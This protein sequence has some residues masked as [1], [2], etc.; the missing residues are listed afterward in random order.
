MG[1]QNS[2]PGQPRILI[3]EDSPTQAEKLRHLLER[4]SYQ[5]RAAANGR[6]A[7]EL[8]ADFQP[9]LVI[10]DIVMPEMN[11]YQL[12]SRIKLDPRTRRIP[13]ILLTSLSSSEDVLEGLDCGADYFI[14]KPYSENYL[15]TS[16]EQILLNR[17]LSQEAGE[18]GEAGIMVNGRSRMVAGDQ[19]QTLSLLISTYEAAVRTNSELMQAQD[20]L[21][22]LNANLE[23]LVA[24]RTTAL[25]EENNV[26]RQSEERVRHLNVILRAIRGVNNLT[27]KERDANHLAQ[28]AC[29]IMMDHR[30]YANAFILLSDEQG[31]AVI[32]TTE[33]PNAE[34]LPRSEGLDRE[35][36]PPC[37]LAALESG[38]IF[39]VLERASFC[40][41]CPLQPDSLRNDT[42]CSVLRH[43]GRVHGYLIVSMNR[44]LAQDPENR[45]LFAEMAA[46]LASALHNIEQA[47][48]V[49]Q[50][51]KDKQR[52]EAELRQ[53]QKMEAIGRLAGGVAH[54]FNN[55]LGVIL[56]YAGIALDKARPGETVHDALQQIVLAAE[57]SADLARQLLAFS[58]RQMVTPKVINL[59]HTIT[60]LKKMLTRLIGED[61]EFRLNLAEDIWN[62]LIDP[63]QVNQILAN[64]AVNARDAMEG[65]GSITIETSNVTLD[66]QFCRQH[67]QAQP[68]EYVQLA[69]SDTGVGMDAELISHIFEPFFT[70]KGEGKGTGLGLSTV[71]GIVRQYAGYIHTYSEPG[72]GTTFKIYLPRFQG[73]VQEDRPQ[74]AE[75]PV[76]G[77]E[78]VLIVEDE[79][80]LLSLCQAVLEGYGHKVLTAGTPGEALRMAREHP[81]EIHLLLSDMVMPEMNGRELQAKIREFKPDI[82]T[83]FMSGYTADAAVHRGVMEK[84][85]AFISKPFTTAALAQKVREALETSP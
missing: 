15:I 42:L 25:R 39:H 19:R 85:A 71:F 8:L 76:R 40:L 38:G 59:N 27:V 80:Q 3:A 43:N 6:A 73:Q 78:T 45:E 57:R 63:S 14:T 66:Q 29:Q 52:I 24:E 60:A 69:F 50:A 2:D 77:S 10:S 5:V 22:R 41:D 32:F 1:T 46:D 48:A 82:K 30:G 61:I 12:C 55:M 36:L 49:R 53:A 68:G 51:E 4:N 47:K 70:T 67:A 17:R 75:T 81:G 83:L 28:K 20:E 21:R 18:R 34:L 16:I 9:E 26:R 64:L 54:D 56:G 35:Y 79:R 11:G 72:M 58:S 74:A 13:V 31:R 84:G 62:L 44:D 37:C 65:I 33:G 7:L 23:D